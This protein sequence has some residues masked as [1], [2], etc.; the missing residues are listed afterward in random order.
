MKKQ[1]LWIIPLMLMSGAC[2]WYLAG[3]QWQS[4]SPELRDDVLAVVNDSVITEQDFVTQMQIR[5]GHYAGQYQDMKQ[6]QVLLTFLINQKLLMNKALAL[7]IDQDPVVQK[8]YHQTVV[9]KFLEA[10]LNKR[11]ADITVSTAEAKDYFEQHKINYNRPARRRGAM[12]FKEIS[13]DMTDEDKQALKQELQ[14]VKQEAAKLPTHQAHFGE[15]A[16]MHS[17][18]RSTMYQGGVIGWLI[19]NPNRAYKWPAAV[20]QA[21]FELTDNGDMSDVIETDQGYFLVRLVAAENV[22]ETQFEQISDGIK[23]KLL[24]DKQTAAKKAFLADIKSTA[25]IEINEGLLKSI[26]PIN[27]EPKKDN[28]QPPAMPV[29]AGVQP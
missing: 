27:P 5:G 4:Q 29:Q 12:I 16:R 14:Q 28:K 1:L 15:L 2:G 20:T 22:Q 19:E 10:D 9:D 24:S 23:Q 8:I 18:D 7:G 11:L 6:K 3:I 21:V 13:A 26:Q 17:D 25:R